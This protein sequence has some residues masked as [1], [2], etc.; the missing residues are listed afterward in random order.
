MVLDY[1]NSMAF[2][3]EGRGILIA[4]GATTP[5]PD[6]PDQTR[7]TEDF[8]EL[9]ERFQRRLPEAVNYGLAQSW[10][11]LVEITPDNSPIVDWTGLDNVFTVAGFSGHGMCLAPG[12]A[13]DAAR[14]IR[15][16]PV[17][18]H[19]LYFSA[20]RFDSPE[21]LEVEELWS[22]ARVETFGD[23]TEDG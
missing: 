11:G 15:G 12:M 2:H 7:P 14:R 19:L 4:A 22:G 20:R 3:T 18:D 13:A 17:S 9:K 1:P 23:P 10:A 5:E 21:T 16:E 6:R 8:D